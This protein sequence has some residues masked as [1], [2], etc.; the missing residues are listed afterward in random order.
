MQQ[1]N[2]KLNRNFGFVLSNNYVAY[3]RKATLI[4][5]DGDLVVLSSGLVG[6]R[7]VQDSVGINVKGD[8]DLR[9][10]A[11]CRRDSG[12]LELSEDVVVLGHGALAFVNLET[13]DL[14]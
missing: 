6:S 4:V 14:Y 2:N 1:R 12:Q 3:L 7:D 9:H 10:A 8:F 5:G 11:R 13:E